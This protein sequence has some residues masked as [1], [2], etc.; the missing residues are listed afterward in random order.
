MP[1]IVWA[2]P[3]LAV[4]SANSKDKTT[5]CD[6]KTYSNPCLTQP[7]KAKTRRSPP[8]FQP[9]QPPL[10]TI[11]P[12]KPTPITTTTHNPTKQ[13]LAR[14]ISLDHSHTLGGK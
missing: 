13:L 7:P 1:R 5:C 6:N 2:E 4:R 8:S 12:N 11:A 14:R 9:K 10:E 3:I